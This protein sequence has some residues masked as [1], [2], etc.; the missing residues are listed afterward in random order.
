M[1]RRRSRSP[2]RTGSRA[3]EHLKVS[4]VHET[5]LRWIVV[6]WKTGI[7]VSSAVFT[8]IV[9]VSRCCGGIVESAVAVGTGGEVEVGGAGGDVFA[10][11]Q[12]FGVGV[13]DYDGGTVASGG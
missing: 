1:R 8:I 7:V 13:V 12:F 5:R 2:L 3:S 11:G 6:S 9:T 4:R 10:E